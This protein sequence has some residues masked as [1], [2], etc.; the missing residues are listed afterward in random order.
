MTLVQPKVSTAGRRFTM[1][2]TFAIRYIPIASEPVTIA[3]NASGTAATARLIDHK[4]MSRIG[5][6]CNNMPIAPTRM[7]KTIVSIPSLRPTSS[8]LISKG[9]LSL[10]VV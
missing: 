4:I 7:H 10:E 8:I 3:G 5:R 9:V 1:V 2:L 6:F